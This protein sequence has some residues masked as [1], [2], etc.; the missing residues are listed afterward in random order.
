MRVENFGLARPVTRA[1]L[2]NEAPQLRVLLATNVTNSIELTRINVRINVR[3][4]SRIRT[5]GVQAFTRPPR[6]LAGGLFAAPCPS[7]S[8]IPGI[9]PISLLDLNRFA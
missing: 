3:T 5:S 6:R 7:P 4:N 9:I 1:V 2:L 8:L